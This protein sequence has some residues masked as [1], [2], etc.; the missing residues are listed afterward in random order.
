MSRIT[1]K[2]KDTMVSLFKGGTNMANLSTSY[3]IET[4]RVEQIIREA[5]CKSEEKP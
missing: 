3:G 2:H 4:G 1:Q 5:M